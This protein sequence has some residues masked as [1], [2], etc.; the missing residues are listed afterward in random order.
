MKDELRN[1]ELEKAAL[2]ALLIDDGALTEVA[3]ILEPDD[4]YDQRHAAIYRAILET[5]NRGV[6]PDYLTVSQALKG[7]ITGVDPMY[8]TDLFN[9][10]PT[11]LN[12][13]EY[14]RRVKKLARRRARQ[15]KG[16]QMANAA[17]D[18]RLPDEEDDL[19]GKARYVVHSAAEALAPRPP[20]EWIVN[21]LIYRKSVTVLYGDGGTK[22]TWSAM[23]LAACV[24]SGA[25]WGD[26]QTERSRVLFIDE[27]NGEDEIAGR[28]GSCLRGAQA[29][30]QAGLFYI[31]LA[32]FHLD[33]PKDEEL[34]TNEIVRHNV[35]LVILDALADL[36]TGD[37][38]SK[39]DT[40]P[41]FNALRRI[42]EKSGAAIIV[43]HHANKTG[44]HRGSSVIKDAPD[45]LLQVTS[46]TDSDLI[47]FK[48]EKNRKGKAQQFNMQAVWSADSFYLNS[49]G[50]PK[51]KMPLNKTQ[52]YVLHYLQENGP[53]ALIN[54]MNDA[55]ICSP[56][57][58]RSAVY[59]LAGLELI[60]RTNP[61]DIGRGVS[62]IY[63]LS[64]KEDPP[65]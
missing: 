23:H 48:T 64:E 44:S 8:V 63:E 58:A 9:A 54:I 34:M 12:A 50:M 21:D 42:T 1:P 15:A 32:A 40:Q 55:D 57:T 19:P 43:I 29:D 35:G 41:V 16:L 20:V 30:E 17:R 5:S 47:T 26:F 2:G 60:N 13:L 39:Q 6:I 31:S 33:K 25:P 18:L 24:A 28:A 27:E 51:K 14:A 45:I 10:T 7:D 52:E 62:A 46:E 11:S 61:E 4:F 38:N 36:M 65:Q 37:E 56:Q 22:K 53:S 3:T 59:H 49:M